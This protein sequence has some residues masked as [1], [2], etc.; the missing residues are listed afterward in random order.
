LNIRTAIQSLGGKFYLF[1]INGKLIFQKTI[2][3]RFTQINTNTLSTGTYIY[4]YIYKNKEVGSGKWI[5][6]AL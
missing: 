5:K 4:S 6:N 3:D 1:D 2:S